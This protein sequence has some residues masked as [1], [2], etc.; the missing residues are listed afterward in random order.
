MKKF[1][2]RYLRKCFQ[3]EDKK[4]EE[5]LARRIQ[6]NLQ[7]LRKASGRPSTMAYYEEVLSSPIRIDE[8]R[9]AKEKGKKIIGTFCNFVPEELIYVCGAIPIRLCAGAYDTI[10]PAE[11]IL[12]Q[13]IC[14]LIKSSLG[15]KILGLPYFE[16]CD[17]VIL[18][19][20]C[21]GKK[22]LGEVLV[23]FLP[24]WMLEVPQ[25]KNIGQAD[26]AW[27]KEIKILKKRL[28]Q[29]TGVKITRVRLRQTI[30][31]LHKRQTAF[32]Q[33]YQLKKH[34]PPLINGRDGLLVTQASFYDDIDRW[35]DKTEELCNQLKSEI[36]NPKS[37]TIRLLLTGAPIIWPNY[38]I[39]NIIE[40]LDA[41]IVADE[42]CSG[43]Q[44][45]YDPVE[46][47]EWTEVAMLRAIANRYLLPSTCPC[48]IESN[49]RIDRLLNLIEEFKVD[50]VIY[51]SLRL[52]QLYDIESYRVKQ[53]LKDKGI[54]MLNIRTDYSQEDVEQIKTRVEAFLEMTKLR[55]AKG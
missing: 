23:D 31:R 15:F 13:D 44:S 21:D 47:D 19:T 45:L 12:P 46:V 18:P 10:F 34:N 17:L 26:E 9:E 7:F 2:M 8:L 16:L 25:T 33:L 1:E 55:K 11:E 6:K 24:V 38:K 4:I 32:R 3:K 50:G 30:K 43:T 27:F 14:P 28:E 51:H 5:D 20:T 35:I 54:P 22:K 42:V 37:E 39:L 29:F 48:F 53:V 41:V 40:E 36:R 49:D 52:C